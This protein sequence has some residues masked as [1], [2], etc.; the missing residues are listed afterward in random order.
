MSND[1]KMIIHGE[2]VDA[3]SGARIEVLNPATEEVVGSVPRGSAEDADRAIKSA[4]KAFESWR[5]VPAGERAALLLKLADALTR[6]KERFGKLLAL[7]HGKIYPEAL[8]ELDGTVGYLVQAAQ[9]ARRMEGDILPSDLPNEQ[10]WIQ[11]VP[12]GVTIGLVAWNFPVALA[13]RKLGP[14]L[15]AGNTMVVKPP[16]DVP[17]SVVEFAKLALEV[18][19]PPG[20]FNVVTGTGS[21]VGRDLVRH[22][23][24][25]LVTHTGSTPAG[26]QIIRDSADWVT[27]LILELGGNAPYI[28]MEDADIDRAVD[29]AIPTRFYNNGQVCTCNERMYLHEKIYD[30]FMHKFLDR[31]KKLT[32]GDQFSGASIGPKV[33]KAER[34]HVEALV[35]S[36][37]AAGAKVEIGGGRP[38]GSAPG[39]GSYDKGYW[40]SPTV[41]T[42]VEQTMDVVQ[43]EIFGPVVPVM[44]IKSF[45]E[46][47]GYANDCEYGLAAYLWTGDLKRLM[48]TVGELEFG[49]IYVNRGIGELPQGYHTGMKKSGLA[50]EDGKY[51]LENYLHK[52]TYYVNF[53]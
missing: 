32:V 14:A 7:E 37:V 28:V 33:N 38:T 11:K 3:A 19:I 42:G 52:K 16:T 53:T 34:D 35:K 44:K 5:K 46:A 17:M 6:E 50:G 25:R 29:A 4:Q 39:G 15:A 13:G 36:A 9:G 20:V 23:L 2:E 48:R 1:Y 41:L 45:D 43:D 40:F 22:P 26:Q 21:E 18:G 24:T 27:D 12:Y 8:E 47:L 30:D 10:I 31:V 49:E 51:G